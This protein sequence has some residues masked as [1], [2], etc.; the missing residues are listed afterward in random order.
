[1]RRDLRDAL[2]DGVFE[3]MAEPV[4]DGFDMIDVQKSVP[5]FSLYRSGCDLIGLRAV[6]GEYPGRNFY[7]LQRYLSRPNRL[8]P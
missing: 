6:V 2:Q 7:S 1:M 4:V 8:L 3:R 5:A